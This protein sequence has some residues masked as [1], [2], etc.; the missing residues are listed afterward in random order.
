[1]R[2]APSRRTTLEVDEAHDKD[3]ARVSAI[4]ISW[5]TRDLLD[6][7]LTSL[8]ANE[9]AGGLE[10]I[11]VDNGSADDSADWVAEHFPDATLIRNRE[12][13]GFARAC[14]QGYEASRSEFV[15]LLNSDTVVPS[16]ALE[17]ALAFMDAH[18]A[19][20][21][22]GCRQVFSDGRLQSTCFRF[23]TLRAVLQNALYL[24]QA[25]PDS[26]VLN[27]SR[28]GTEDFAEV[29][30]VDCVAGSFLL[31]RRE[32]VGAE[33]FD[34]GYFMYGE[35]ADLLQRMARAGHPAYY[36]PHIEIVH[37]H[38][39]SSKRPAVGAWAY[40][41]KQRAIL[42]FLWK[43]RG[44]A[45]ASLANAIML[46]ATVPRALGWVAADAVGLLRGRQA[47]WERAL[48]NRALR[49]HTR[50]LL[51]PALFDEDWA[52]DFDRP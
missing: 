45:V 18:P 14:N 23:P 33:L 27:W 12:N 38:G 17:K 51:S 29:R 10:T 50:A 2:A 8:A 46:L 1:M 4:V 30:T 11:V 49:F 40:E 3:G 22:V 24:G 26:P 32:A 31:L 15:L 9:I 37:H 52:P 42:R 5:N 48:K 21:A 39:A 36:L 44:T 16:D 19:A 41:A 20:G 28:Y 43:W 35:E 47:G 13:A 6:A 7:C 34:R 25:F